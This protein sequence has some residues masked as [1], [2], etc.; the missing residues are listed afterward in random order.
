M[1][2]SVTDYMTLNLS[3]FPSHNAMLTHGVQ[4]GCLAFK[5]LDGNLNLTEF[6]DCLG[7]W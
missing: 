1:I 2:F 5:S 3:H 6:P 4:C 7:I